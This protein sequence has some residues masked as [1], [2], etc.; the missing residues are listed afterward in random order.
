M[1][2][3]DEII[4]YA[5]HAE[6]IEEALSAINS[7]I[8]SEDAYVLAACAHGLGH[9]ARRFKHYDK[10]LTKI[11]LI[12]KSKHI[13]NDVFCGAISSMREDIEHFTS[14]RI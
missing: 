4:G 11:I 14:N 12:K 10:E 1:K 13:D 7:S 6:H 9:L 3:P 2:T 8:H 5:L